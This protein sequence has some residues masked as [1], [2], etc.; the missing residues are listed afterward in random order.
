M[1]RLFV[2]YL[3]AVIAFSISVPQAG[4]YPESQTITAEAIGGGSVIEA[5]VLNYPIAR[6]ESVRVQAG[7]SL[8]DG[9][10]ISV[11]PGE[12]VL[13]V[14]STPLH[15]D[16]PVAVVADYD[17]TQGDANVAVVA[18]NAVDGIPDGQLALTQRFSHGDPSPGAVERLICLFDAPSGALMPGVQ[19]INEGDEAAE[20]VVFALEVYEDFGISPALPVE[21]LPDGSFDEETPLTT[22]INQD[23]GEVVYNSGSQS[24]SL[25]AGAE[26]AANVAFEFEL[27]P[28][29]S[30]E[31]LV[32]AELNARRLTQADGMLG[33]LFI[34]EQWASGVFINATDFPDDELSLLFG[35]G[36]AYTPRDLPMRLI[37]QNSGGAEG[38]E[39]EIDDVQVKWVD[40]GV[41]GGLAVLREPAAPAALQAAMVAP[42]TMLARNQSSVSLNLVDGETRQPVSAPYVLSLAKNG[43][44]HV[45]GQ[46][47]T[48]TSGLASH[49]FTVPESA[50]GAWSLRV[51][52]LGRELAQGQ[53]AL[54][55]GGLLSIETDKPIYQPGQTIQGRVLYLDNA[56]RPLE[57]EVEISV[58]D[59]KG[60]RIFKTRAVSDA[61]GVT[62]FELPLA[63]EVNMGTW[64]ITASVEGGPDVESDIEVDRYVLPAFEIEVDLE[65]DWVLVD[66][67]VTGVIDSRYFFGQPVQGQVRIEA[68]RYV[69]EWESYAETTVDLADG[70]AEFSLPAV[71]Y[72]A[73]TAGAEGDATLQLKIAVTDD[74]GKTE[75][76]DRLLRV[77]D[78]GISLQLINDSPVIKPGLQQEMIVVAQT[79]G[80]LPL[81]AEV[82]MEAVFVDESGVSTGEWSE[83]LS[84]ENGLATFAYTVPQE[85][86]I[87]TFVARTTRDG[88]REQAVLIA[89]AAY[90]PGSYFIHA[91][92]RGPGALQVG[93]TA[94]FDVF[95]TGPGTIFYEVYANGRT[96]VSQTSND[97]SVSFPVTPAMSGSA[98]LMVYQIQPNNEVSADVLP[99]D[100]EIA[101][102]T[103]LQ[104]GFNA[105]EV[106][107]G[108]TVT[109]SAQ[110]MGEAMLGVSIVDEAVFALVEGRL[111][112]RNVFAELERLF[113]EPQ[114]EVHEPDNPWRRGYEPPALKGSADLLADNNLQMI[115][116]EELLVPQG[117]ELDPFVLFNNDLVRVGIPIELMPFMPPEVDAGG[118]A[119]QQDYQQPARVRTYFPETWLWNPQWKTG[120]DGAA[121]LELTAPDSITTWKAQATSTSSEGL[122]MAQAELR[123]F[124]DFFVEP[125][126]PVA[127]IRGDRFPMRVR[128]FNYIDE[129][130]T[131]LLTL[132]NGDE[133]G[134]QGEAVQQVD[135]PANGVAGAEFILNPTAV[136][137]L[138]VSLLAQSGQRADAIR[139]NLRVEPEGMRREIVQNGIIKGATEVL[140]TFNPDI[141]LPPI[142]EPFEPVPIEIV[143]DS[144]KLRIAVTG[145]LLGQS[146]NGLADLLNMPYGCGEQNMIFLAPDV[147]ILRYLDATG[148]SNPELRATAEF[149]IT[150]G[151]QRQLTFQRKDGSFSAFGEQDDEGSLWLT[152]FVLSTF[153]QAREVYSIDETVIARAAQWIESHQNEDGSWDPVGTVIHQEMDGGLEGR[154]GLTAYVLIALL[155]Y[156][157]GDA[158]AFNNGLDFLSANLDEL[159]G[160][161]YLLA[162]SAYALSLTDHAKANEALQRLLDAA[163]QNRDG[164]YWEPHPIEATGYAI[165][166]LLN[167]DRVEAQSALE[168]MAAQRNS[169][170]G[171]GST[172]DT[173]VAFKAMTAAAIRQSR[174]LNAEVDVLVD[175]EVAHTFVVNSDNFDVLQSVELPPVR[176][177]S[178]LQRGE[179]SV[180]YQG[181]YAYNVPKSATPGEPE[182]ITLSVNYNADH[183]EV[184]D[185]VDVSVSVMYAGMMEEGGMAIVDVSVPTGFGVVQESIERLMELDL[186]KRIEQAGRKVIVYLDTLTNG[187]PFDFR[188]QIR[189]LFPVKADAGVS[190]AYLYY[191]T[192]VKAEAP[193]GEMVVADAVN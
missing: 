139:K 2:S 51:K 102:P 23:E 87:G 170:G 188:F 166:A 147:E 151:Y 160:N 24:L 25:I 146:M 112:L 78:A 64:K 75:E 73:G 21:T 119:E 93:Q 8:R 173:V 107:P 129:P 110:G 180:L 47:R 97:G 182:G 165:L 38:G 140:L 155:E 61:F 67:P 4:A 100:V 17:I 83:T 138:P 125:D 162:L 31:R 117:H 48:G 190:E 82:S 66:E 114:I 130:Q 49:S 113:M 59:A 34:N 6:G 86:A 56:L 135:V 91:A 35:G 53:V 183:I 128:V 169:L 161:D 18:L 153:S 115:A 76:T 36:G 150:T 120:P 111:N 157:Q 41:I 98:R 16:W 131:V 122:G 80:G 10:R 105:E 159:V 45:I 133:L 39:V 101:A 94:E 171:Y 124:Q 189:A 167:N 42:K 121:R 29:F 72:S 116:S 123:V 11:Q 154:M 92:Q 63:S 184:D 191:D 178:L 37:V 46:G 14:Q 118:G 40:T 43:I 13:L 7:D 1:H 89:N 44:E 60:I 88:R 177:L 62:P 84:V 148:Q 132:Q 22:N 70:R 141:L 185:I 126:L 68:L 187:E 5:P 163:N 99:F 156:G 9:Y 19:V 85:T 28:G 142:G 96:L 152:A 174:D 65:K 137:A 57:G 136:G 103:G 30:G 134:L 50:T 12:G 175:G 90:S 33:S 26:Q 74:G 193:G 168:W 158:L 181:A 69:S 164:M 20:V 27:D 176:E 149:F 144:E 71:Q 186:V 145:S 32:V 143:P 77:A 108:D 81:S 55:Q 192:E 172:Q 179:G 109:L 3:F 106:K 15:F 79:P 52:A 104:I 58:S 54:E 95:A 127:V